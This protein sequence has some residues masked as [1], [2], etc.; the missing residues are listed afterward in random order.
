MGGGGVFGFLHCDWTR[1][2][3]FCFF[4]SNTAKSC[5]KAAAYVQ[6][7]TFW[8]GFYSSAAL[9]RVAMQLQ[10]PESARW[11]R[12]S[13]LAHV[14]WKWNLTLWWF[15]IYFKCKLTFCSR[16]VAGFSPTSTTQGRFFRAAASIR[17]RFMC[18][19]SSEKVRLLFECSF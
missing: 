16:K 6:F 15:Q 8:W 7:S 4:F 1:Q 17:L 11:T 2:L 12:K 13:G 18:N 10:S 9:L 3:N 14:K 5:T 19:L